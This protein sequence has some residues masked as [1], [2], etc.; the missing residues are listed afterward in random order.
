MSEPKI[1]FTLRFLIIQNQ[2]EDYGYN[3]IISSQYLQTMIRFMEPGEIPIFKL[4]NDK[5]NI[6]MSLFTYSDTIDKNIVLVSK[7]LYSYIKYAIDKDGYITIGLTDIKT[8]EAT[9]PVVIRPLDYKFLSLQEPLELLQNHIANKLRF[10]YPGQTFYMLGFNQETFDVHEYKF[11]IEKVN[12]EETFQIIK[13][14]DTELN[15][16]FN[17]KELLEKQSLPEQFQNNMHIS[18]NN[19]KEKCICA[20]TNILK[21]KK[22]C[23]IHKDLLTTEDNNTYEN[24]DNDDD[25]DDDDEDTY[26]YDYEIDNNE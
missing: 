9:S 24:D 18:I 5:Y 11:L 23:H 20:Y 13:A 15:V 21:I 19:E 7:E 22:L 8:N 16:D 14:Y 25:Y 17:C 2:D 10:L 1:H 3:I 6:Y 26:D 12:D 4:L